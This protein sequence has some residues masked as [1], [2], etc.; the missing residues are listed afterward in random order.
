MAKKNA[1]TWQKI[2]LG[3]SVIVIWHHMLILKK[4][5]QFLPLKVSKKM[6]LEEI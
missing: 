2:I 4:Y 5:T 3:L 1:I 6:S